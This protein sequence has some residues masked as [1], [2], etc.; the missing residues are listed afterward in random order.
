M[1]LV[2]DDDNVRSIGENGMFLTFVCLEFLDEGEDVAMI[3]AQKLSEVLDVF[4][5]DFLQMPDATDT[6]EI[7]VELVVQLFAVCH[8]DK[9]P[10]AG[11]LSQHLL[12]EEDH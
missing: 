1:R 2:R 12:G 10:V 9:C 3:F 4:R 11:N 6:R 7:L 8:E 5:M